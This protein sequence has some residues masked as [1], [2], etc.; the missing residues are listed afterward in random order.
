PF[1]AAPPLPP[2]RS[3]VTV[4]GA[5]SGG[6]MRFRL[7]SYNLLAEI[8]ATQQ[9]YPYCDF[10]ALSWGYRKTN[11]LRELLEAG[12]DVLC[13]QEMQSDAYHQHFQP[14][15][16]EKGYDGLYKAKTREGAM[17][18]VDGCAIFWRRAKFRLSE[19]YTVEF[20][21]CARRAVSA[22]PGLPPDDGH[23]FLMR[24]SKDN[25]AQVAVLE[26]LQRPRG[27]QVPPAS[28]QLCV[29]NTHLYSNPEL[30]DVKLW[31]CNALLQE[32]EGFVH[33]RQLPLLV[34]K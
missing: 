31:Q 6:G 11:L 1:C 7:C 25:I 16:S 27:R 14:H 23:H 19:N 3:L 15:L 17:G 8:Y 30:P 12:A 28:A 34:S 18:K 9:A 2:R 29:A 20:N 10:W 24:V 5:G 21:E 33:S 26:V 4:K 22:M 13:L 32:L